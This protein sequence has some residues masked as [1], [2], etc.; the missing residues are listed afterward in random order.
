MDATDLTVRKLMKHAVMVHLHK[1]GSLIEEIIKC[2][3]KSS[4]KN[5]ERV[6]DLRTSTRRLDLALDLFDGFLPE[7]RT[8]SLKKQLK[9]IRQK[10]GA[11]RN[12]DVLMPLL[13]ESKN[14]LSKKAR[15]WLIE[16]AELSRTKAWKSLKHQCQKVLKDDFQK[17]GRALKRHFG[18]QKSSDA[19][20]VQEF[21]L[22]EINRHANK[23]FL[24]LE[25]AQVDSKMMH[26]A[27]IAGRKLR[28]TLELL[29]EALAESLVEATCDRLTKVQ[30]TL[31]RANDKEFAV[32]FLNASELDCH[33][34]SIAAALPPAIHSF[35]E[36]TEKQIKQA[37]HDVSE[38]AGR[39]KKLLNDLTSKT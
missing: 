39:V 10:A 32:S 2:A 13:A 8:D 25:R 1:T 4:S 20:S 31:G 17:H 15:K 7:D 24:R 33:R 3:N 26:P 34:K 30:D 6:H 16:R 19:P 36:S 22:R 5:E 23:F 27:R 29:E 28:Y 35:D 11:V 18:W 21:S 37:I 9:E 38:T 12:L 14:V